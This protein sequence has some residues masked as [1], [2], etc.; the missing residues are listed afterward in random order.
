MN[1]TAWVMVAHIVTLGL[2]SAAL[3]V[4]ACLYAGAPDREDR[5]AV[6]RHRVMCRYVFVML[7]SPGA[8]LAIVTG[9]GLVLLRGADGDWL[10]AKLTVVAFLAM[11]HAYCA[12][13]LD[14]QGMESSE[15]RPRRRHPLLIAVPVVLIFTILLLVLAK[16][17]VVLEYQLSPKPAGRRDQGRA[18]EGQIQA[19]R[20]NGG[21]WVVQT[22]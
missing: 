15:S 6:Q 10:L 20:A 11:F 3:L 19:T 12:K 1:A 5:A 21:Q 18:E 22:G 7:A 13:S 16:P 2:W 4:L 8:I 9:C 14:A 17:H